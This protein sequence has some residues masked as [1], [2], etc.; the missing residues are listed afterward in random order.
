MYLMHVSDV[1]M[2]AYVTLN[3][4]MIAR[5]IYQSAKQRIVAGRVTMLRGPSHTR[6]ASGES[7]GGVNPATDLHPAWL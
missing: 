5:I 1:C 2:C 7:M 3:V 6:V 4:I